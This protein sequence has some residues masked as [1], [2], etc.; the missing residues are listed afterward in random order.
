MV[1]IR[2]TL[3]VTRLSY[4]GSDYKTVLH[5]YLLLYHKLECFDFHSLLLYYYKTVNIR[6]GWKDLPGTNP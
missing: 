6:P 2:H 4:T 1:S 3:D 5:L